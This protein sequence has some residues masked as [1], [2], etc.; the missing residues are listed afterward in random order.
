MYT[1]KGNHFLHVHMKK[2]TIFMGTNEKR[3]HF[4]MYETICTC[5]HKKET[6]EDI[7]EELKLTE[8]VDITD[9]KLTKQMQCGLSTH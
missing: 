6:I 7:F 9:L 8:F 5:T 2:E 3:N 4:Y 1:Q